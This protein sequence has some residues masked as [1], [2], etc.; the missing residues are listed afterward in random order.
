MQCPACRG[1]KI[2]KNGHTHYGKQ[3][4]QCTDC[5]RQFVEGGSDWFVNETDQE[6]INKLLLER[7]SLAG[8]CRVC[9]V[10]HPWLLTYLKALYA[11][12]PD[13]LNADL[14]EP[15]VAAYVEQC[16]AEELGRLA[17]K[18]KASSPGPP[19]VRRGSQ[20]TPTRQKRSTHSK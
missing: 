20:R 16:L 4:Y 9:G 5:R 8:I 1:E 14:R 19:P 3:N 17:A 11:Q 10:S 6:L 7:I 18:K 2:I 12:L 15:P 13:D